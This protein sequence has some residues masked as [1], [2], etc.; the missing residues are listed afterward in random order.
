MRVSGLGSSLRSLVHGV[1]L[2]AL[3]GVERQCRIE[4]EVGTLLIV[5]VFIIGTLAVLI[6]FLFLTIIIVV[7]VTWAIG[8]HLSRIS[9]NKVLL[10]FLRVLDHAP[11]C[12]TSLE[13][14]RH[15]KQGAAHEA[16]ALVQ[17]RLF[18]RT[19]REFQLRGWLQMRAS[20][21]PL[22][23]WSRRLTKA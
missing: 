9:V 19:T 18:Q 12:R 20:T 11:Q 1:L 2:L 7:V 23:T 14:L 21:P 8:R 16:R 4:L 6:I 22:R 13:D 5:V 3:L 17:R 10:L 15:E